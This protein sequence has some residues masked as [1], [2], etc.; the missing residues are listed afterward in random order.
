MIGI[1]DSGVGGLTVVKEVMKQLP[2]YQLVYFGDT[3]RTPYGNKSAELVTRYAIQDVR[4]LL[5]KGAKLIIA[6]CNTASAVA[7]DALKRE[8]PD[9]PI[10]NVITP[11][12][13]K[14]VS[15]TKVRRIGVIGTTATI[16]SGIYERLLR[17]KNN[18]YQVFQQACP[19]LVPL[20][21]ENW[22]RKPE[23]KMIVRGYLSGLKAKSIDALILGCTHYPLLRTLIQ[24]KVGRRVRVVDPAEETVKT[25]QRFLATHQDIDSALAKNG[26]HIFYFSDVT[27]KVRNIATHWLG[28]PVKIEQIKIE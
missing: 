26:K 2:Q 7:L 11:A 13:A 4:L 19:L 15:I 25:V 23:T 20:V 21:E 28:Q 12:V 22:L 17:E 3:A 8:F 9:V 14:A 10:F 1:F 18:G 6:G 16:G 5:E 24:A 27:D